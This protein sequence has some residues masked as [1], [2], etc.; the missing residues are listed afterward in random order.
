MKVLLD[1]DG[2]L[3]D[4]AGAA[5]AHHNKPS[6]WPENNGDYDVVKLIG[7]DP[8]AFWEPLGYEFWRNL[9]ETQH[10]WNIVEALSIHYGRDNICFLTMPCVTSGCAQ[11]KIE[12][13]R[14]RWPDIP[15][16]IGPDKRFCAHSDSV[17]FDDNERNVR[18]FVQAGG[19]ALLMPAPWNHKFSKDPFDE[20]L[21][22]L[23]AGS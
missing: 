16:L 10:A 11:G 2:V 12:W 21:E 17:L 18:H 13:L 5:C 7:M 19:A 8:A 6:P 4:F 22:Y 15:Y 3:A 23:N 14:E 1:V 9:P 20:L